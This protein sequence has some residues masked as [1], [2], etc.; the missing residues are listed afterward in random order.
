MALSC[1]V[2]AERINKQLTT[3]CVTAAGRPTRAIG[4]ATAGHAN[5]ATSSVFRTDNTALGIP[6]N[7]TDNPL[8]EMSKNRR[9]PVERHHVKP[10]QQPS[11][12]HTQLLTYREL[13]HQQGLQ[14][15]RRPEG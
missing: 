2:V 9:N 7:T 8:V 6:V 3:A 10:L 4:R 12:E 15:M 5:P 1:H 14:A 13:F 11:R